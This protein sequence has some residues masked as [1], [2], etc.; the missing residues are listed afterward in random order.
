MWINLLLEFSVNSIL[1][2]IVRGDKKKRKSALLLVRFKR[3]PQTPLKFEADVKFSWN[4]TMTCLAHYLLMSW[5]LQVCMIILIFWHVYPFCQWHQS[6]LFKNSK[7]MKV[8]QEALRWTRNHL[9][10]LS[11]RKLNLNRFW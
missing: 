3:F 1:C 11:M 5:L 6:F 2:P 10:Y 8:I 9:N 4:F 7:V